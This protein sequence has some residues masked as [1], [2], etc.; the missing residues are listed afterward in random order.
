[1]DR[2]RAGVAQDLYEHQIASI[3]FYPG[4]TLTDT[5]ARR[6]PPGMDTS[7]MERPE[8]AAKAIAYLCLDPMTHTGQVVEARALVDEVG[9]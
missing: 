1:M 5:V 3:S 9:L 8:T 7:R 6:M 4:F 2:W